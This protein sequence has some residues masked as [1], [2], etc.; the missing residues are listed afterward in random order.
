MTKIPV[1]VG[2]I[3]EG[4]RIRKNAMH[5][6]FGGPKSF[7]AELFRVAGDDA[8]KDGKITV[9]GSDI[10]DLKEG[11]RVPLGMFIRAAGKKLEEDLEGVFER[12]MHYY[13]NYIQGFMHLNSRDTIWCRLSKDAVK[14]GLKFEHIGAAIIDLFKKEYDVIEKMDLTFYTEE[15]AVNKNSLNKPVRSM[16]KET[17]GFVE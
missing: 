16:K 1:D 6:E 10:P 12:R 5:V 8:V 17:Q 7:G 14:S 9:V 2:M 15:K 11:E 3:Y 13:F 4:E